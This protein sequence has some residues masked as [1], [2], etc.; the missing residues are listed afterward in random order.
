MGLRA[1]ISRSIP[2]RSEL[3]FGVI[4]CFE[5]GCIDLAV[6]RFGWGV[7]VAGFVGLFSFYCYH[8]YGG[9]GGGDGQNKHKRKRKHKKEQK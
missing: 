8:G 6:S 3:S 7:M 1:L 5:F 2:E 9:G 4:G